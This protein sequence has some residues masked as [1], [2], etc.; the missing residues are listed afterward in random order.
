[1]PQ[2][3][4]VPDDMHVVTPHLIC[5][6]AA[7][8]IEFYKKAFNAVEG[9]RL[10]GPKGRLM[11][12]MIRINGSAVMLVDE[13]PEWGAFGPKSLKGSPVTIHLY[14]EDV[15]AVVKQAVAAGAK[16]T[17]PVDD[18]FWG[19]RYGKLEDPFGHHWSVATHKRDVTP[20]EMKE[21]MQKMASQPPCPANK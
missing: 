17:M 3:K 6:G 4:A 14:V 19:D 21:A 18:M 15:D 11:H 16:I 9:G 12:A 10:P 8:A 1:M 20:E 2:V 13:M 5:A 7:D